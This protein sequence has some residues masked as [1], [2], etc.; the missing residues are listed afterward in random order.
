MDVTNFIDFY[1]G[2]FILLV[3]DVV[4]AKGLKYKLL[5]LIKPPGWTPENAEQTAAAIRRNFLKENPG[6]DFT[7]RNL[8]LSKEG[9]E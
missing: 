3:K 1:F 7:S 4:H 6:L 9:S 8:I 5:Y 2:E